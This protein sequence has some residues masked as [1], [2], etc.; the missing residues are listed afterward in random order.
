V[1]DDEVGGQLA[2]A[3]TERQRLADRL[4]EESAARKLL[5]AKFSGLLSL[6]GSLLAELG[7]ARR[8]LGETTG[9]E[10]RRRA[11]EL[12]ARLLALAAGEDP[13]DTQ[14]LLHLIDCA[15]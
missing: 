12:H 13:G 1:G 4:D 15:V 6:T 10:E 3:R 7:T 11:A 8:E 2:T 5:E 14:R 9:A